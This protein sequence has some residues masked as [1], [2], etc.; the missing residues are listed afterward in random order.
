MAEGV[1]HMDKEMHSTRREIL[2]RLRKQGPSSVDALASTLGITS[3]GVRRHLANLERDGLVTSGMVRRRMGR[4]SYVYA[5]SEVA[6]DL[7]PKNYH[8]LALELLGDI[9]ALDG[10]E[11]IDLLFSRRAARLYHAFAPRLAGKDLPGKVQELARILDE[12]GYLAEWEKVNGGYLLRE[13]NCVNSRVSQEY[14]QA[15]AH[16]LALFSRLLEAQVAREEHLLR[17]D[18]HCCYRIKP[19]A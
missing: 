1:G 14:P 16:Q 3:M 15:C 17:G 18:H 2:F 10:D 9:K 8:G 7:F 19:K 6:D 12:N 13:Y 5:L 11:K 4:P